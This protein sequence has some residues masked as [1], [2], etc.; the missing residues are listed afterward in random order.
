MT[1]HDD[2][3][4]G[5]R[6][7][8]GFNLRRFAHAI[9]IFFRSE[10]GGRAKALAVALLLLMLA[11]NVLNVV[12]SYVGR[13]FMTAIENRD[14][15]FVRTGVLYVL[16]FAVTTV[17]AV[18]FRFSEERL[19]LLWRDWLTRRLVMRYLR[20]QAYYRLRELMP[21]AG[22]PPL[23]ATLDEASAILAVVARDTE[24]TPSIVKRTAPRIATPHTAARRQ[25][26]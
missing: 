4:E 6:L 1:A 21:T 8:R 3:G 23:Q 5:A 2:G 14:T 19:A 16:V 12:N 11:V 24:R 13:D 18:L 17:V 25:R 7:T 10:V 26:R 9:Q 20:D 22:A 15:S